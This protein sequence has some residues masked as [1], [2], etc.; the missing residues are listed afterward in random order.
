MRRWRGNHP[1]PWTGASSREGAR[2]QPAAFRGCS[3]RAGVHLLCSPRRRAPAG[4][5]RDRIPPSRSPS[6]RL[7]LAPPL[8]ALGLRP[9]RALRSRLAFLISEL[10]SH[11]VPGFGA[12]ALPSALGLEALASALAIARGH[13][14]S[15]SGGRWRTCLRRHGNLLACQVPRRGHLYPYKG[16]RGARIVSARRGELMRSFRGAQG[17]AGLCD[18]G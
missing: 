13:G 4:V 17:Q 11:E 2:P 18:P 8:L 3:V 5:G 12:P 16:T 1:V 6:R 15:A 10:A 14:V 7:T 9:P